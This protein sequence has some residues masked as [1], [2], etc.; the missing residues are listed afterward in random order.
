MGDTLTVDILIVRAVSRAVTRNVAR[1]TLNNCN[2]RIISSDEDDIGDGPV[3]QKPIQVG[4][5][6]GLCI[7]APLIWESLRESRLFHQEFRRR[8]PQPTFIAAERLVEIVQIF[9]CYI[10][11]CLGRSFQFDS[12]GKM[13]VNQWRVGV[14]IARIRKIFDRTCQ[15]SSRISLI[16]LAQDRATSRMLC[17]PEVVGRF[18]P[19]GS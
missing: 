16:C 6:M 4:Q 11:G 15:A 18:I 10:S 12:R 9:W 14:T 5:K 1:L 13:Q 8:Q 2:C 17:A 19:G 7:C 3:R